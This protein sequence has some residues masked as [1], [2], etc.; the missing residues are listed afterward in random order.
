M[1]LTPG[2]P[3][4]ILLASRLNETRNNVCARVQYAVGQGRDCVWWRVHR[5]MSRVASLAW[6]RAGWAGLASGIRIIHSQ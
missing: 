6:D 3:P 4:I 5:C 2:T 1:K